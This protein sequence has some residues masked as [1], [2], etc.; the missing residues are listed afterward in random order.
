MKI[1][2]KYCS[3]A[4]QIHTGKCYFVGVAGEYNGGVHNMESGGTATTANT[5]GQVRKGFCETYMVPLPGVECN[6]GL[7]VGDTDK[8]IVYYYI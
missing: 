2:A 3:A 5:I 4:T 1:L 8:L 7:Y 6:N